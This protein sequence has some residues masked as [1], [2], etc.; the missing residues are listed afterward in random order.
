MA[1]HEI[2]LI[3]SMT[4]YNFDIHLTEQ[5]KRWNEQPIYLLWDKPGL[6]CNLTAVDRGGRNAKAVQ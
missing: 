2:R 4:L 3:L 1:Y 5:S 6:M